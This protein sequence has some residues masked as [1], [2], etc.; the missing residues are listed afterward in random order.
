MKAGCPLSVSPLPPQAFPLSKTNKQASNQSIKQTNKQASKPPRGQPAE[1]L[2]ASPPPPAASSPAS[3][4][5]P[6]AP[7]LPGGGRTRPRRKIAA[8]TPSRTHPSRI[9]R[10][11]PGGRRCRLGAFR[12]DGLDDDDFAT[13][14]RVPRFIRV[15]LIR[16]EYSGRRRWARAGAD[17]PD[18]SPLSGGPGPRE[19]RNGL[20]RPGRRLAVPLPFGG[21]GPARVRSTAAA[22]GAG[23][24]GRPNSQS[25]S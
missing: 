24:G 20:P 15:G 19:A 17:S 22:A 25:L 10:E 14:A 1:G 23:P 16:D 13:N 7:P 6:E 12:G 3:S 4:P 11:A 8:F 5:P 2:A 18:G 21:R 9:V